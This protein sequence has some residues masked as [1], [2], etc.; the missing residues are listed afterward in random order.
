MVITSKDNARI[1]EV[2]KL[3][4]KKTRDKE[5]Q[6]LIE[7]EH[8]IDVAI[9]NNADIKEVFILENKTFD[10]NIDSLKVT[11]VNDVVM[12]SISTLVTP[13]GILAIVGESECIENSQ[14]VL[15]IDSVQDPGNLGTLIRTADAFNFKQI[16]MSHDTVDAYN[17]KVLR[18][19]QG[20]HFHVSLIRTDLNEFLDGFEGV[21][22]TTS[23]EGSTDFTIDE[24][25]NVALILGNEG[26]GVSTELIERSDKLFKIDMTGH[27][28]SLNVAVAGGI[29]MHQFRI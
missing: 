9:E 22:L 29:L 2:R 14:R 28:E 19:A 18:S 11:I 1:K 7:G 20:S 15:I 21:V 26:R 25:N 23:L 24:S 6:F 17:E 10:L 12:K 4:K 3:Q 27:A 8:L 16:V 13:P 5:R